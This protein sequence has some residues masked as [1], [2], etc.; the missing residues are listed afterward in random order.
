VGISV[1]ES[2]SKDA[3]PVWLLVATAL[4][5]AAGVP[6]AVVANGTLV[7]HTRLLNPVTGVHEKEH[8]IQ[9]RRAAKHARAYVRSR[10]FLSMHRRLARHARGPL[11]QPCAR[12]MRRCAGAGG[13]AQCGSGA[14]V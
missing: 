11:R 10:A 1:Y 6:N 8:R 13:A 9:V 5:A 3:T 7:R 14:A 12:C 2:G 4:W